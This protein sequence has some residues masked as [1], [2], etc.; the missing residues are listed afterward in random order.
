M[1][2]NPQK[3]KRTKGKPTSNFDKENLP[4]TFNVKKAGY[5]TI[6]RVKTQMKAQDASL[7]DHIEGQNVESLLMLVASLQK[8]LED[9]LQSHKI[10]DK[11]IK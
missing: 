4:P 6:K 3:E 8:Q 5:D 1:T 9:S 10:K 7:F 2:L 11:A